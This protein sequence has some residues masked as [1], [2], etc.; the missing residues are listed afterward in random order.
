MN[1]VSSDAPRAGSTINLAG[2]PAY[3]STSPLDELNDCNRALSAICDLLDGNNSMGHV[4]RDELAG[5]LT[6]LT[7][8]QERGND[9]GVNYAAAAIGAVADLVIPDQSMHTV[10][11][12]RLSALLAMLLAMQVAACEKLIADRQQPRIVERTQHAAGDRA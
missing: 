10:G 1:D 8:Q 3:V 11:R 9:L 7:E 4:G 2:L 6:L 12:D 5:L